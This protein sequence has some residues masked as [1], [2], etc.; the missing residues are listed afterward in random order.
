MRESV[1]A[2]AGANQTTSPDWP[3]W[4]VVET[5]GTADGI[6]P[7]IVAAG[8]RRRVFGSLA[9]HTGAKPTQF[10]ASTAIA[11]VLATRRPVI[12]MIESG[13][14]RDP[15]AVCAVP[16]L[17]SAEQVFGVQLWAGRTDSDPPARELVGTFEYDLLKNITAHGP[18]LEA[19]ILGIS[20]QVDI[21]RILPEIWKYFDRFDEED[22]YLEFMKQIKQGLVPSGSEFSGEIYLTGADDVRR[23]VNMTVRAQLRE[24]A[25]LMHGLVHDT[26]DGQISQTVYDREFVRAAVNLDPVDG[27]GVGQ[28]DL[29]TGI[30]FEW[31]R[32]PSDPFGAWITE[33]PSIHEASLP[34]FRRVLSELADGIATKAVA[35]VYVKFDGDKDWLPAEMTVTA[36]GRP[37]PKNGFNVRQGVVQ[38]KRFESGPIIW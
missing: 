22:D 5:L 31:L 17:S 1:E 32:P 30:I 38:V 21:A 26:S 34:E 27:D 25:T 20:D 10:A 35:P 28:M 23:R 36:V 12:E 16:I 18:G 13:E 7:F 11:K 2:I 8:R 24:G 15:M 19:D 29:R 3:A 9:R 33:N 14:D 4:T 6:G 37:D